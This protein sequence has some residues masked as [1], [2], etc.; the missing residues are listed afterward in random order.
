M[1]VRR[2]PCRAHVELPERASRRGVLVLHEAFG[3]NED[4]RRIAQRFARHGYVAVVPAL[5]GGPRC[6][7]RTLRDEARRQQLDGW[8]E[9]MREQHGVDH[10]GIVGFCMGGGF[11]IAEVAA[12]GDFEAASVNYGAVPVKDLRRACPIVGSYGELDR[13][14]L[15]QARKLVELLEAAGVEHDVKVYPGVGHSFMN[16]HEGWQ[17]A[18]AAVPTP[19]RVGHQPEA[20]DDAWRRVFAFFDSH[21]G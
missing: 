16:Q 9:W 12:G 13:V 15:P 17:R 6:L 5:F 1:E 19:M 10:A 3:L 20:A 14:M 21:L 2:G 11:A 8:R 18:L 4:M 7:A